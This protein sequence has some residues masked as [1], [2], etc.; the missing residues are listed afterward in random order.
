[1]A[2]ERERAS[3]AAIAFTLLGHPGTLRLELRHDLARQADFGRLKHSDNVINLGAPTNGSQELVCPAVEF[4][5]DSKLAFKLDLEERQQGWLVRRFQF[6][7]HLS[8]RRIP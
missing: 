6:H 2:R 7:L 8:G 3:E 4:K 1:M 5:S